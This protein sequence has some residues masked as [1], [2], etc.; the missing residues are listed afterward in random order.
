MPSTSNIVG[1]RDGELLPKSEFLLVT[2]FLSNL[3]IIIIILISR[4]NF[5]IQRL[6]FKAATIQ[7]KVDD[8]HFSGYALD[9]N[10]TRPLHLFAALGRVSPQNVVAFELSAY[11]DSLLAYAE[12]AD[13]SEALFKLSDL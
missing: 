5:L 7:T 8:I 10:N 13:H 3:F 4:K 9:L 11:P 1:R 6:K 12:V 2:F